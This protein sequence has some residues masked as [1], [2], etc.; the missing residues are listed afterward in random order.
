M[1]RG[2]RYTH[3]MRTAVSLPDELFKE[4]ENVAKTLH[5]SRSELY[6]IAL[7]KFLLGRDEEEMS[8]KLTGEEITR[9][10]N[11]VYGDSPAKVDEAFHRA[12]MEVM[13]RSEW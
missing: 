4:A 10:L 11:E 7:K 1:D 5:M 12:Q 13:K 9:K 3:V 8:D 2:P 6:A